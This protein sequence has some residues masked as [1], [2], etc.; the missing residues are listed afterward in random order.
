MLPQL[1]RG[2]GFDLVC[3]ID[4]ERAVHCA[5]RTKLR[6]VYRFEDIV[7]SIWGASSISS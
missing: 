5:K 4:A 2:P 1:R 7:R 6:V 3:P